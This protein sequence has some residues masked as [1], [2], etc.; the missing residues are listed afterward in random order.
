MNKLEDAMKMV[1]REVEAIAKR[2]GLLSPTPYIVVE[3]TT[4]LKTMVSW[5]GR[6]PHEKMGLSIRHLVDAVVAEMRAP[7][8]KVK[9]R[10]PPPD[11]DDFFEPGIE[12][13]WCDP[14]EVAR[15]TKDH[16]G[17]SARQNR[18]ARVV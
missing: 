4:R 9:Q 3:V 6:N 1:R 7:K 5:E 16:V 10:T 18:L 13:D 2:D 17:P 11:A 15:Y 14:K 8:L 12:V